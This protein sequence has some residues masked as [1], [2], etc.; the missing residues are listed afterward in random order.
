MARHRS[1]EMRSRPP[2]ETRSVPGVIGIGEPSI[3]RKCAT[4]KYWRPHPHYPYVGMCMFHRKITLED[5]SCENWEPVEIREG[6]F[7]W[8]ST[9]K[10]R[11]TWEEAR[12][13]VRKGHRIHLGAYLE[14][15]IREEIYSVF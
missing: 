1:A 2:S 15:D 14:P 6:E 3:E 11:V 10:T 5:D 13:L 7:Y 12:E 8:C 4:C 9:C